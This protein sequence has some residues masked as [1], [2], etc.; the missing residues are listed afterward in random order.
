MNQAHIIVFIS[1]YWKLIVP[2]FIAGGSAYW[3]RRTNWYNGSEW[4]KPKRIALL[5]MIMPKR[6]RKIY[7]TAMMP[8]ISGCRIPEPFK[9]E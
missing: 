1:Q 6:G 8:K 2:M 4:T 3:S 7:R 9:P 5:T